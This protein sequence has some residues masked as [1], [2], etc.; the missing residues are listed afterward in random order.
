M[1]RAVLS[2]SILLSI[3]N[4]YGMDAEKTEAGKLSPLETAFNQKNKDGDTLIHTI[5]KHYKTV[6]ELKKDLNPIPG[7]D[8]AKN[9]SDSDDLKESLALEP[10]K[11]VM[12]QAVNRKLLAEA[13]VPDIQSYAAKT[14]NNI[15]DS[16]EKLHALKYD[17]NMQNQ[18]GKT[19]LYLAAQYKAYRVVHT[20][21][22]LGA[23]PNIADKTGY[24]PLM[25]ACAQ[26]Y[27]SN[28]VHA[29]L[30]GNADVNAI[31]GKNNKSTMTLNE[32]ARICIENTNVILEHLEKQNK[33][34][35]LTPVASTNNSDAEEDG[36]SS[37]DSDTLENQ[38]TVTKE[39]KYA[40]LSPRVKAAL[41]TVKGPVKSMSNSKSSSDIIL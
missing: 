3:A 37:S 40:S 17:L 19:A 10:F 31:I 24:T 25:I 41:S 1:K 20:L 38:S 23:N 26:R 4:I 2:I 12:R 6:D 21:L 30:R 33:D 5:V 22:E 39:D 35:S 8:D 18:K 9:F 36:S 13:E 15:V 32:A 29:L 16:I 27:N 28:I 7:L 11:N 34:V 14:E